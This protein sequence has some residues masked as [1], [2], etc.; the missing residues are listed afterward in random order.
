MAKTPVYF[1]D[2]NALGLGKLLR[3]SGRRD[4]F[5]PGHAE[6]PDIHD[7]I[8]SATAQ[9]QRCRSSVGV[10]QDATPAVSL[11]ILP[12]FVARVRR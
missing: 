3:G 1:A 6:V 9:P 10:A 7:S 12:L 2:E 8:G 5:Y 4:V 11:V